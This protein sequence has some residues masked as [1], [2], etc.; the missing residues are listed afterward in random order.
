[1]SATNLQPLDLLEP[2]PGVLSQRSRVQPTGQ[3]LRSGPGDAWAGATRLLHLF[4]RQ[5][6]MGPWL[7]PNSATSPLCGLLLVLK[8]FRQLLRCWMAAVSAERPLRPMAVP[9]HGQGHRWFQ[10]YFAGFAE[11]GIAGRATS[12]SGLLRT[13]IPTRRIRQRRR[14]TRYVCGAG[15]TISSTGLPAIKFVALVRLLLACLCLAWCSK[16]TDAKGCDEHEAD[17]GNDLNG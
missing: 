16:L 6:P 12:C 4:H 14:R 7:S 1:M 10:H 11:H 3:S 9:T 8:L 15:L 17:E 5:R 2:E 13:R